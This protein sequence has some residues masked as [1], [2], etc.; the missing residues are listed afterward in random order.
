MAR[1]TRTPEEIKAHYRQK[2]ERRDAQ[3]AERNR[4]KQERRDA[5]CAERNRLR[6]A[7]VAAREGR[8]HL[9]YEERCEVREKKR[10]RA[11]A[12]RLHRKAIGT[13][14]ERY[15]PEYMADYKPWDL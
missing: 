15:T 8:R 11:K 3:A 7:H 12:K 10:I 13:A 4:L 2:Q 9:Q 6:V 14:Q 1:E 5:Q